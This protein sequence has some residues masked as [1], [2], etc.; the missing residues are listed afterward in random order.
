MTGYYY[1]Y[2]AFYV[3]FESSRGKVFWKMN[4]LGESSVKHYSLGTSAAVVS[5]FRIFVSFSNISYHHR[6]NLPHITCAVSGFELE[7][8]DISHGAS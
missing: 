5:Y 8:E 6:I 2:F 3:F 4:I 7:L 1:Y